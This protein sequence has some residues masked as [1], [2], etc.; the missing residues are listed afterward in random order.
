MTL[1]QIFAATDFSKGKNIKRSKNSLK[2]YLL[3]KELVA[4]KARM[5]KCKFNFW[6]I[7][8]RKFKNDVFSYKKTFSTDQRLSTVSSVAQT[9][10]SKA[11]KLGK[12]D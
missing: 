10:L 6:N 9:V 12:L 7:C 11:I 4:L 2:L 1:M 5:A 8:T 3:Y